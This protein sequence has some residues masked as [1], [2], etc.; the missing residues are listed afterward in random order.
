MK[1][2]WLG[3][4]RDA[5]IAFLASLGEEVGVWDEPLEPDLLERGQ[6]DWLV[7]YGYRHIIRPWVLEMFPGRVINLHISLL[8]WN[9]GADPNL[10]SFLEDSPKGVSIHLIDAGLDTGPILAQREVGWVD[11]DTLATSYERL[12][13]AV[14]GL[15]REVWPMVRS[16]GLEPHPQ[17]SGG[18]LHRLRD[19]ARYEHLLT[20]GWDTS[21]QS[22]IGKA[23][24]EAP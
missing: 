6:W 22:L 5:L 20:K 3:P 23:R 11:G 13:G 15:F 8:P 2:L 21:V 17:P 16:A 10:W 9:R 18:S 4:K 1:I 24:E 14:E 19:R 12:T 7:S